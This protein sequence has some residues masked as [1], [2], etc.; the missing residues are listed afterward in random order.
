MAVILDGIPGGSILDGLVERS[1]LFRAHRLDALSKK[2]PVFRHGRF[3]R[4][5]L[6]SDS[7]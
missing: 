7:S 1:T 6:R 4:P 2:I 3:A 5:V